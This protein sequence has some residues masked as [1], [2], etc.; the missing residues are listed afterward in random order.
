[1]E[2]IEKQQTEHQKAL[3]LAKH[4]KMT[5]IAKECGLKGP[6]KEIEKEDSINP[7]SSC[8]TERI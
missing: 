3:I 5:R 8:P 6:N 4:E 1:M 7:G 2:E